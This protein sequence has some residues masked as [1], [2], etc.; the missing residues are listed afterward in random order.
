MA[1]TRL[2]PPLTRSDLDLELISPSSFRGLRICVLSRARLAGSLGAGSDPW[3]Y[4]RGLPVN[5]ATYLGQVIH[6]VLAWARKASRHEPFLDR[7]RLQQRFAREL[8]TMEKALVRE[9]TTQHL[10]PLSQTMAPLEWMRR[11]AAIHGLARRWR[12]VIDASVSAIQQ[13][14]PAV[15]KH[16]V[17][18]G[19]RPDDF[20]P[21]RSVQDTELG[22]RGK[23]DLLEQIDAD[24]IEI[25]EYKSGPTLEPDD[26]GELVPKPEYAEQ[27]YL[28]ALVVAKRFP[29]KRLRLVLEGPSGETELIWDDAREQYV[30][31]LLAE[32][33][34]RVQQGPVANPGPAQCRRCSRRHRCSA[35]LS[36]APQWWTQHYEPRERP[37]F[38]IW[39][40]VLEIQSRPNGWSVDLMGAHGRPVTVTGLDARHQWN[41]VQPG[42]HLYFFNLQPSGMAHRWPVA[43]SNYHESSTAEDRSWALAVFRGDAVT[44]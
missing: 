5:S 33:R 29:R 19:T 4:A 10:V 26:D 22:V 18:E 20:G 23:I 21:E 12:G 37:P 43:P 11:T 30:S 14:Q 17:S 34:E 44:K 36:D 7:E 39:G 28:Y 38:D 8:D 31:S 27:L 2:P 6:E 32:V 9:P 41:E 25:R 3:E 24:T 42:E 40:A 35:Y 1:P 16:Q 13:H 15:D